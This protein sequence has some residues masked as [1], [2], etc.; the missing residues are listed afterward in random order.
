MTFKIA[1]VQFKPARSNVEKNAQTVRDLLS[2]IQADLIVLPELAN[3]GYLY[4]NPEKLLPYSES[5]DGS[6]L[7]LSTLQ[8][9]AHATGG[10]IVAGYSEVASEGLFNSAAAVSS[11]G[12]IANYRKTH[13]YADE[14]TLFLPGDTGFSVFH[15]GKVKIGMMIC[16]DWIFPEA[17]RTL[18]LAG[19]QI[20]AHPANLVLPY[21]QD[22]MVTRSIEN[23][24]FTITANRIGS[25]DLE[26]TR[27]TFT[28]QSQ[29]TRPNGE[30]LFRAPIDQPS[31]QVI[32]INPDE[33][34]DKWI[35]S[36]NHLFEDRQSQHYSL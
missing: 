13:L 12:V 8:N 25:E 33:A 17:A 18:A 20:I 22:A 4:A 11:S 26:S 7:F 21:C 31:V 9:L 1:L 16:F 29:I 35:S 30:I 28:G 34:I 15:L 27:L 23:R 14:K 2:G 6:G 24:V 10:V 3:C 19:A 32:T 5:G 36:R